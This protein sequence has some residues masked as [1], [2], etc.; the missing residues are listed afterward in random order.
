ML[1][2]QSDLKTNNFYIIKNCCE[3]IVPKHEV[4]TSNIFFAYP[5]DIDYSIKERGGEK[6][7]RVLMDIKINYPAKDPGY[8]IMVEA[9]GDYSI[10][11]DA[12]LNKTEKERLIHFTAIERSIEYIRG[13]VSNLTSQFPLGKYIFDGINMEALYHSKLEQMKKIKTSESKIKKA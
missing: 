7:F 13:F 8:S 4:N 6:T 2:F 11:P 5:I 10:N 9:M 1:T 3:L 12:K